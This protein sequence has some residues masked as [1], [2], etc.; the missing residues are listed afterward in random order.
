M[1]RM[2]LR[3]KEARGSAM[4]HYSPTAIIFLLFL[5]FILLLT[6]QVL[7]GQWVR[8]DLKGDFPDIAL[9]YWQYQKPDEGKL[10][11]KTSIQLGSKNLV[12]LKQTRGEVPCFVARYQLELELQS[13]VHPDCYKLIS[14]T[15]TTPD[16]GAFQELLETRL[17]QIEFPVQPGAYLLRLTLRDLNTR[18]EGV[19][20]EPIKIVVP[21]QRL[22]V[23]DLMLAHRVEMR[24]P[25]TGRYVFAVLPYPR[26]IYGILE[27]QLFYYFEIY[28]PA[29]QASQVVSVELSI[30]GPDYPRQV[31]RHFQPIL[32][33]QKLPIF[34]S[35][36]TS[37]MNPGRYQLELIV[38]NAS[39][40]VVVQKA[41]YFYVYQSPVDVRY[42]PYLE[43]LDELFLIATPEEFDY[44]KNVP[45][46]KRQMAVLN[47]WKRHDPNPA[48]IKNELMSEFYRRVFIARRFFAVGNR[49]TDRAKVFIKYGKPAQIYHYEI[50]QSRNE[51]E[52]WVYPRLK[53]QAVF[54]DEFG[55]GE[56]RL[57]EP[58][59]IL[60][61]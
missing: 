60:S 28:R 9:S 61:R 51:T 47:F 52:V 55:F 19:F 7:G 31:I 50:P 30:S 37:K 5:L 26:A 45:E 35:V 49:L 11:L 41:V 3:G 22:S 40:N 33:Q 48:T 8:F 53:F 44:L 24:D 29:S 32:S 10:Y 16:L 13:D 4:E 21:S 17:H 2:A 42:R 57:V 14:D 25:G 43:I 39:E 54:L 59:S 12:F 15:I 18:K 27:P 36:N 56:Y 1:A 20:E 58:L 23:S 46:E 34:A 38:R 6:H